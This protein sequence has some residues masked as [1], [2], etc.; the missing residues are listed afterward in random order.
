MS[1]VW[2]EGQSG[3]GRSLLEEPLSCDISRIPER[4][5]MLEAAD[6]LSMCE[7]RRNNWLIQL[8]VCTPISC[9][10]L[11]FNIARGSPPQRGW[12]WIGWDCPRVYFCPVRLIASHG[13]CVQCLAWGACFLNHITLIGYTRMG[14]TGLRI[15]QIVSRTVAC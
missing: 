13:S 15:Q 9:V 11:G 8:A 10:I 5:A 12:P 6:S 4:S 14:L 3:L 1:V 2:R 7:Y